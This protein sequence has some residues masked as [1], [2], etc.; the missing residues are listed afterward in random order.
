MRVSV[1]LP[2]R[3]GLTLDEMASCAT[4][5]EE[6][7]FYAVNL[8]DHPAPPE[9]WLQGGG[10]HTL[11]PFVGLTGAAT[12]TSTL[13]VHTNIVVL[14]Y[15]HPRLLAKSAASLDSLSG[16]RLILGVGVGYLR[17]E[18]EALGADFEGRSA[19]ADE[20]LAMLRDE[21]P[22][23][24]TIWVGGNSRA[25]M[26]RVA[27]HADGWA[28]MPSPSA[29]AKRLGTPG[30]DDPTELATR[31]RQ[32]HAMTADAGRP[33]TLDVVVLAKCLSGFASGPWEA[34]AAIEEI[35]TLREA[36][37]TALSIELGTSDP[38]V[39]R[40]EAERFASDVLSKI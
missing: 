9:S 21:L 30:L 13:R 20:A 22:D 18:F 37:G 17:E 4:T 12:A 40:T 23:S 27:A 36:G 11:D 14:G 32:L 29:A 2:V 1:G 28:P 34:D 26:R 19:L 15:R 25:A 16:G 31:I 10:H 5:A 39:W 8:T 35:S 33:D 3:P 38:A 6:L 7:G 24:I